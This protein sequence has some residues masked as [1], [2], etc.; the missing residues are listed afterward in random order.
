MAKPSTAKP[1]NGAVFSPKITL[2]NGRVIYAA[3][4]GLKAFCFSPKT[5]KK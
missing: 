1:I 4:Y 3:D 2:K 5:R